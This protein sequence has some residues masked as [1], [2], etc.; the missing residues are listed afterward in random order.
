MSAA[1]SAMNA[2]TTPWAITVRNANRSF[3]K[4]QAETSPILT[5][6]D[7]SSVVH[8]RQW[9]QW[10]VIAFIY[11]GVQKSGVTFCCKLIFFS[12]VSIEFLFS[13]Y[14]YFSFFPSV[15]FQNNCSRAAVARLLHTVVHGFQHAVICRLC[16][17]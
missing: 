9:R 8:Y 14:L 6:A 7:V 13:I 3:I 16:Q 15:L 11:R 1:V 5:Y 4:S 12:S 2:D 17:L 10:L